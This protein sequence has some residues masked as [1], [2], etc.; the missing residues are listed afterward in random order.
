M[1]RGKAVALC[2]LVVL[3]S[4]VGIL[5]SL[6]LTAVLI[7]APG[8]GKLG[9]QTPASAQPHA[10]TAEAVKDASRGAGSV[11][12]VDLPGKPGRLYL[13]GTIHI[14]REEDYPLSPG[15]E[16][17]YNHSDKIVLELPPGSGKDPAMSLRMREL[18]SYPKGSN[19]QS[20]V[21]PETWNQVKKWAGANGMDLAALNRMRPWLAALMVTAVEYGKLGARP[22]KGVDQHFEKRAERDGKKGEGLETVELQLQ[23]FAGLTLEQQ[24]DMLEQTLAEVASLPQE[25]EKMINAWKNGELDKLHD[26]L[27]REAER[28]PELMD[29]FLNNR[30][31]AWLDRLEGMLKR[32]ESVMVLVGTGHLASKQGLVELLKARGCRVRH[33]SEVLD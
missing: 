16:A 8:C 32:G 13:C 25:Y 28:Y 27:F 20:A 5:R 31:L 4:R 19:L 21:S 24:A 15:Y 1:I 22:D 30:N 6:F 10:P 3:S 14:L 23:L 11:W 29:L 33:H 18:G 12:V 2:A 7:V 9:P 26:M 17:A